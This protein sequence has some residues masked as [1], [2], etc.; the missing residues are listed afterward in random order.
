MKRAPLDERKKRKRDVGQVDSNGA[1]PELSQDSAP[2]QPA[3]SHRPRRAPGPDTTAKQRLL[4]TVAIGGLELDTVPPAVSLAHMA[5]KVEQVVE[6]P[7]RD[8]V[9]QAKLAQDGCTGDVVF[10]VYDSVRVAVLHGIPMPSPLVTCTLVAHARSELFRTVAVLAGAGKDGCGCRRKIAWCDG[11]F[12][13][14]AGRQAEQK[15]QKVGW[16]WKGCGAAV[17]EAGVRR[18]G[19]REK[20]APHHSKPPFS[21]C[22]WAGHDVTKYCRSR[23]SC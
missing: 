12:E 21:G 22:F 20:M 16:G 23:F 1:L 13:R 8:V 7:P 19:A 9:Q 15:A 10:I 17:G 11:G 14:S 6:S 18:G 3:A 2:R 4:R 5:G